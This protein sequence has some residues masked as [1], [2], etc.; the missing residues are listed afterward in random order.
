MELV[1]NY[2]F[3]DEKLYKKIRVVKTE[4]YVVA[5][6]YEDEKRVWLNYSYVRKN[7]DKAYKLA[8]VSQLIEK[9]TNYIMSHMQRN[10][11][12]RP[13]GRTY[14]ITSKMPKDFMWSS[15][16]ILDLRDSIYDLAPKNKYG[17][18]YS[19][20]TLI[21]KAELLNKM[22]KDVSMYIKNE[23]GEFIK[24]WRAE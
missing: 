8:D 21:S 9:S 1:P 10:L 6:S 16:D 17:E 4:N 22:H 20:F 14:N 18:P 5:W 24:I 23:N 13:S 15:R 19:N 12:K 11:V 2:F 3:L 7:S